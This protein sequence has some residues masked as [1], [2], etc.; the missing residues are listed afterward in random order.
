MTVKDIRTKLTEVQLMKVKC[1]EIPQSLRFS[2]LREAMTDLSN[3]Q[4]K[5]KALC[6]HLYILAMENNNYTIITTLE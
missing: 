3:S 1:T 5:M 6:S 2:F 4:R